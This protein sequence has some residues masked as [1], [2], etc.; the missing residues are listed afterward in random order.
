LIHH[1]DVSAYVALDWSQAMHDIAAE[2]LAD[3]AR[4]VTF[5]VETSASRHGS[6]TWARSTRS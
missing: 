6:Q 4:R 3:L 5:V 2:H 1:C